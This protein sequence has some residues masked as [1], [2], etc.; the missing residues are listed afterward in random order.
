MPKKSPKTFVKKPSVFNCS[1]YGVY[2]VDKIPSPKVLVAVTH[3]DQTAFSDSC[4]DLIV[5]W[6]RESE[7][8]ADLGVK[9]EDWSRGACGSCVQS[10]ITLFAKLWE[11]SLGL[12]DI[13]SEVCTTEKG[14]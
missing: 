9:T 5:Q 7:P 8:S 13:S 11:R 14:R 2:A 6:E 3:K 10:L 1:F 12:H 4:W